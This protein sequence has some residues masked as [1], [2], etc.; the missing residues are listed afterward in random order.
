[1]TSASCPSREIRLAWSRGGTVYGVVML[2]TRESECSGASASSSAD[3]KSA[4]VAAMA[5]LLKISVIS[6]VFVLL[7]L[8]WSSLASSFAA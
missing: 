4:P 7:C 5:V 3:L 6:E 8:G 2:L 1:M